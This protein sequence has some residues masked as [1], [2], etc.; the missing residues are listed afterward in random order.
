MDAVGD[1]PIA[2]DT[3]VFITLLEESPVS[4]PVVEPLFEAIDAGRVRPRTSTPQGGHRDRTPP[5]RTAPDDAPP[6]ASASTSPGA[7]AADAHGAR[8]DAADQRRAAL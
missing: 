6:A 5:R 3:A 2:T 7:S 1:E 4:P 8:S